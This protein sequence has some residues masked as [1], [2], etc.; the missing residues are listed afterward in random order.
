MSHN[1]QV[2]LDAMTVLDLIVE[3]GLGA[4]TKPLEH[5][6]RAGFIGDHFG[7]ELFDAAIFGEIENGLRERMS[8]T[9]PAKRRVGDDPNFA[10]VA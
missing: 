6:N 7:R 9:V 3:R 4:K 10:D 8:Q 1:Q 2:V 5:S